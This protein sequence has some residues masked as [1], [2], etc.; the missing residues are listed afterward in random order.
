MLIIT[1]KEGEGPDPTNISPFYNMLGGDVLGEE[2]SLTKSMNYII[3]AAFV[4]H[5]LATLC[6]PKF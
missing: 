6:I 4:E 1:D 5:P 3:M 2:D